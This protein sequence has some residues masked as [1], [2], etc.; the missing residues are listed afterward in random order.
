[1]VP[2][3]DAGES[4]ME[5]RRLRRTLSLPEFTQQF[6]NPFLLRRRLARTTGIS[7]SAVADFTQRLE[8]ETDVVSFDE[9]PQAAGAGRL[10]NARVVPVIKGPLNPYRD[11]IAVGRAQN[12]DIVLRDASVSKLHAHFR[13]LDPE[14]V[15]VID[16]GSLNGTSVN[17]RRLTA[18]APTPVASG[19][20][21]IFGQVAVQ[22]LGP[23][24]LYE[25]L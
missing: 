10:A 2:E 20:T 14:H 19:D 22:L 15:E 12:C 18:A 3:G 16:A 6:A 5:W 24:Q 23:R 4:L 9:V 17:G 1:M 21:I 7:T 11:R 25:L 13:V 8:F